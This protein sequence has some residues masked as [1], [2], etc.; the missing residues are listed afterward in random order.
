MCILQ[1]QG[2]TFA[3]S[4]FS[5][6]L[7]CVSSSFLMIHSH[8]DDSS[9]KIRSVARMLPYPIG[10]GVGADVGADAGAGLPHASCFPNDSNVCILTYRQIANTPTGGGVVQISSSAMKTATT[11]SHRSFF[12]LTLLH[13]NSVGVANLGPINDFQSLI[14]RAPR[15]VVAPSCSQCVHSRQK[16]WRARVAEIS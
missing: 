8:R 12:L 13:Q 9:L 1:Q 6:G 10:A 16:L 5:V 3:F 4:N 14:L 2:D 7:L 11:T 15:M